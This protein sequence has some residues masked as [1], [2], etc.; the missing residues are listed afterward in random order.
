GTNQASASASLAINTVRCPECK[1]RF[2][3]PTKLS[4]KRLQ[5]TRCGVV[6]QAPILLEADDTPT[7]IGNKPQISTPGEPS[8]RIVG[9]KETELAKSVTTAPTPRQQ[10]ED[11]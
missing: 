6:F 10:S 3:L 7:S 5:C 1:K 8:K 4:G 9:P 2:N 11:G